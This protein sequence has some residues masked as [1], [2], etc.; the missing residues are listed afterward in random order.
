MHQMDD[1]RKEIDKL[2]LIHAMV[3]L[4]GCLCFEAIIEASFCSK[5]WQHCRAHMCE[6]LQ[7][8]SHIQLFE[9]YACMHVF[10]IFRFIIFSVDRSEFSCR[11]DGA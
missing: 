6:T 10:L 8:G 7:G 11:F 2:H 3:Q 4:Y 5:L 9:L 1:C